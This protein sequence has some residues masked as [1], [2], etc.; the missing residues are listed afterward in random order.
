MNTFHSFVPSESRVIL[1]AWIDELAIN[2]LISNPRKTKLGDFRVYKGRLYISVN[3]NL[4]P[5]SFLITLTH[6]LAHAFVYIEHSN[7]V[8][9]HGLQWKTTFKTML[10]NFLH[11]F[12]EDINKVLSLYLLNPKA[13]TLSDVRLSKALRK[14]DK[15]KALIIADILEGDRF[16]A[17]NGKEFKKGKKLRKRFSCTQKDTNRVYLFHPLAEVSKMQ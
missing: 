12:P 16:I 6:E 5:Y 10:F 4:N 2:L 7:K 13:S 15:Q 14:Y 9:P 11:L 8:L 1:Q 17:S 3:N